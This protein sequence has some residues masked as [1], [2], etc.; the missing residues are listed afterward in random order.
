[1]SAGKTW[2]C[3]LSMGVELKMFLC[4]IFFFTLFCLLVAVITFYTISVHWPH[5]NSTYKGQ[6]C[7]YRNI[8]PLSD[9]GAFFL[10]IYSSHLADYQGLGR[11]KAFT[12]HS[13][14]SSKEGLWY[15]EVHS[16]LRLHTGALVQLQQGLSTKLLS[17]LRTEATSLHLAQ[18]DSGDDTGQPQYVNQKL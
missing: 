15:W 6:C 4:T 16:S 18:R 9:K 2:R 8:L 17:H 10:S 12:S 11:S 5:H 14:H 13:L 1:M 3:F 7:Q